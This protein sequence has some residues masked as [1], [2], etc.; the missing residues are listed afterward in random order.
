MSKIQNYAI[1]PSSS[2][3]WDKQGDALDKMMRGQKSNQYNMRPSSQE[4]SRD[5]L[6]TTNLIGRNLDEAD[7]LLRFDSTHSGT[8]KLMS[9]GGRGGDTFS[10]AGKNILGGEK[11]L[12]GY[13][14]YDKGGARG[15]SRGSDT[16]G[17][18]R[19]D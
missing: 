1:R 6:S 2:H 18:V 7:A 8:N 19:G 16:N 14:N 11:E 17:M 10:Q 12:Y 13:S 3:A 9:R 4:Q 5:I 15:Y